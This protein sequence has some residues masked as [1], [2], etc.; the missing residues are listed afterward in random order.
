MGIPATPPVIPT[1]P[2]SDKANFVFSSAQAG[3]APFTAPGHTAGVEIFGVFNLVIFGSGGPNGAWTGSG[4]LER[5]FDGGTTWIVCNVGGGGQQAVWATGT[6]VSL[7]TGEC[8]KGVLYRLNFTDLSVGTVNWRFSG[9]GQA[10]MSLSV[11]VS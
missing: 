3:N 8:E 5:S 10:A 9:N 2:A 11:A 6:D 1:P 7:T 4:R